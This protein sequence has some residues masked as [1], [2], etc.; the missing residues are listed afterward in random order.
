MRFYSEKIKRFKNHS[1]GAQIFLLAFFLFFVVE[2]ILHVYPIFYVI[3]NSLKTA[4]EIYDDSMALTKTWSFVNYVNMFNNFQ[5]RGG[6][7]FEE[8]LW[9]SV[10]Q[11][12]VWLFMQTLSSVLVA[13]VLAKFR[14]PGH[15]LVY[16]IMIFKQ[17]IPIIGTGGASYKL[18]HALNMINNPWT[19]WLYWGDGFDYAAFIMYGTFKGLSNSYLESAKL[20]GASNTR[21][22][23]SIVLPMTFPAMLALLVTNFLTM[24]NNY[25]TSQ[26][27]L[28]KYPNLAY[29]VYIFQRDSLWIEDG[30]T[31]FYT[32]LVASAT[33]GLVIYLSMQNLIVKN[34]TVGG[35]K[36]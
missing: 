25:T 11:T 3:N 16:G 24:W 30:E 28:N 8:L 17:I 5:V 9:N 1:L 15:G 2:L 26:V 34:L 31:I 6:I 7:Y 20:D 14:F 13:Y 35:L 19:I 32:A 10:W 12:A 21:I 27:T 22:F 18:L 29:G 36:G 4:T 33:P 23:F